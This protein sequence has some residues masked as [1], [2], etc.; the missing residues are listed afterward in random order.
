MSAGCRLVNELAGMLVVACTASKHNRDQRQHEQRN[1]N[2]CDFARAGLPAT[3][4]SGAAAGVGN[5]VGSRLEA[6]EGR[7]AA[8]EAELAVLRRRL[9]AKVRS[10]ATPRHEMS[11]HRSLYHLQA[12]R[13]VV[14]PSHP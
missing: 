5:R 2:P 11:H 9:D 12:R 8:L 3:R 4:D 10:L 7:V 14:V 6:L 13:L 1:R